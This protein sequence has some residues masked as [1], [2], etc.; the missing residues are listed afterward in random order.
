MFQLDLN[1]FNRLWERMRIR[2]LAETEVLAPPTITEPEPRR[3]GLALGGG[4][5]KG[6][7][8]LGVIKLIEELE[9]PIDLMVGTS[10]GGAVTIL[11]AAGLSLE[12][13]VQAFRATALRRIATTDPL[14]RGLIGSRRR[15]LVLRNLL[16]DRTFADLRFPCGVVA[17]DLCTGQEVLITEGDLVE[18]ILA[19]TA[20]P[21]IFP[22]VVRDEQLL[23]D[24]G[25]LNNLPVDHA[26]AMGAQKVVAIELSDAVPGFALG[27]PDVTN[28]L[29]RLM[30]APQQFAI[31]SR[32]IS[33]MINRTTALHLVNNPPT[34]LLRP[35]V[36]GIDTLDMTNPERGW[37][38]GEVAAL[39]AMDDLLALREWRLAPPEPPIAPQPVSS[40]SVWQWIPW[41][42]RNAI[43]ERR[44]AT[45][46][47]EGETQKAIS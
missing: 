8:H 29:A 10:T 35:E 21:S 38:A 2:T 36:A 40:N 45:E 5:G 6:S 37:S 28:P 7:A 27:T 22:P 4:G 39:A 13:I 14:R 31:A 25:I 20:L 12:E 47:T 18:A 33:M 16:A 24:G 11:Y 41:G 34:V 42:Q 44:N 19:T 26:Y 46:A 3:I 17:A 15:E 32:A 43:T 9:L 30:L 23:A 1:E